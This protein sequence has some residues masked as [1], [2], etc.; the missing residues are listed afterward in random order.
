[1]NKFKAKRVVVDGVTYPSKG[2]ADHHQ[3]L[4]W[5]E[6]ARSIQ[7]L[8]YQPKY[9]LKIN[10][11]VIGNY[12]ADFAYFEGG[13][14]I[15]EDFK[16]GEIREA[17]SLRMRVFMALYPTKELRIVDAKGNSKPFKQRAVTTR[18]AA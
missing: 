7:A 11:V 3:K 4:K 2:E 14:D 10:G 5:L 17:D 6:R 16:G 1:M 13:R 12:T 9:P 15:V 8:A 18:E